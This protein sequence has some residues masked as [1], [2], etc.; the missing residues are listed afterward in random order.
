MSSSQEVPER[1]NGV[2]WPVLIGLTVVWVLLWGSFTV[3]NALAGLVVATVVVLVFPLPPIVFGGRVRPLGL[4]RLIGWFAADL[5][6]A[7]VQVAAQALRIGQRPL[8]AVIEVDLRSRSDLY[9]TLTAQL[10]S[11]V[12]GSLVVEARRSTSTLFLHVLGVRSLA[13]VEAA[14]RRALRQEERV[15]RALASEE[16]LAAY[17]VEGAAS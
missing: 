17:R 16:E 1:R 13:D 9:L 2:Q 8:N 12:P 10:L 6:V 11:L 3:A 5:V 15:M 4:A 14:R 7:S